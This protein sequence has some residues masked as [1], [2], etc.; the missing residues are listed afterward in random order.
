MKNRVY[1]KGDKIL[2]LGQVGD[3][4]FLIKIGSAHAA[5]Q[6]QVVQVLECGSFFG[7]I[8]FLATCSR[9][10]FLCPPYC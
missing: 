9:Q 7:E 10:V 8:A 2:E 5:L 4:L 6:E 1:A 3:S